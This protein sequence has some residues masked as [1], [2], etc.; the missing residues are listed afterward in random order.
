MFVLSNGRIM[1]LIASFII[2]MIGFLFPALFGP[3]FKSKKMLQHNKW[4]TW[5]I[6][7][8][9]GAFLGNTLVTIIPSI[10]KAS[11]QVDEN[12]QISSYTYSLCLVLGIA[13]FCCVEN[14]MINAK[15]QGGKHQKNNSN[16]IFTSERVAHLIIE[17]TAP[18]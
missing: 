9:A 8:P 1:S 5:A 12:K 10:Y 17:R 7:F 3:Y 11:G 13:A 14:F 15:T 16:K 18:R 4:L 2:T 6:G